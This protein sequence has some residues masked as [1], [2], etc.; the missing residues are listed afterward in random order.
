MKYR[1]LSNLLQ[2]FTGLMIVV[3]GIYLISDPRLLDLEWLR[4]RIGAWPEAYIWS[5][6]TLLVAAGFGVLQNVVSIKPAR[7]VKLTQFLPVA[8]TLVLI[9]GFFIAWSLQVQREERFQQDLV[10]A[11]AERVELE[12]SE[13]IHQTTAALVRYANRVEYLGTKDKSFLDLD[14]RAYLAQLPILKRMGLIDPQNRVIW[15]YPHDIETQVQG[16]NQG[17]EPARLEALT[18]AKESRQPTLSRITNLRSGGAGFIL[19][20][21]LFPKG[22]FNGFIYATVEAD[23]LFHSFV[24]ADN[25]QVVIEEGDRTIFA[26]GP[27]VNLAQVFVHAK[28]LSIGRLP[29]LI[30]ITPTNA[31]VDKTRSLSPHFILFAGVII[32]VLMGAYLHGVSR[33]RRSAMQ[34]TAKVKGLNSQLEGAL[35][36]Q[37][38]ILN[39]SDRAIIS[40]DAEGII[41]TFNPAATFMLGYKP[42]ELIGKATPKIFHVKEETIARAEVLTRELGR[43]VEPGFDAYTIKARTLR[44]ADENEWT[45]VRR[46]G[47][48]VP[49]ML[50]VTVLSD[51]TGSVL[52]Y[53]GMAVDLTEKKKTQEQ[54]VNTNERL[55]RIIEATGE[56]IWERDYV[57]G[58]QIRYLSIQAQRIFGFSSDKKPTYAEIISHVHPEDLAI[59]SGAV[60]GHVAKNSAG[61][62]VEF[63]MR[64]DERPKEYSWIHAR[65]KV[66][67]EPNKE[68]QLVS[69]VRDVTEVVRRRTELKGALAAAEQATRA[70]SE[71]LANIS[72]EIRTPLNG[73]IGMNGLLLDTA[74]DPI[75][76]DYTEMVH[77]SAEM[78]LNLINEVLDF[79]KIEA[80]KVDFESIDFSLAELTEKIRRLLSLA[81]EKKGLHLTTSLAPELSR[82]TFKGDPS[83][84]AQILVNLVNNAIKFTSKGQVEISVSSTGN[85]VR[86]EVRDSGIGMSTNSLARIFQPFTQADASTNRKFGGTGL[87][88]SICKHLV[89][90]MGGEIGVRSVENLGSTF[91]FTLTLPDGDAK[92]VRHAPAASVL[93]IDPAIEKS[94]ILLAEDNPVNQ[95]IATKM[96]EKLGFTVQVAANGNEAL[97]AL[98]QASFDLVLMDCQMPELDGYEATRQIRAAANIA[99]RRVPIVAMTA[100]AMAGDRQRC[101]DAGM[102]D[103]L[104]KPFTAAK[105]I[106][107]I[108]NALRE[109]KAS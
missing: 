35:E 16:Y 107:I 76:R 6:G 95:L 42:E 86:V 69:T 83:R 96:L 57:E 41:R 2:T 22:K 99:I 72:H 80:K 60:S 20:V 15:S 8:T 9:A 56:G 39:S 82:K 43:P 36:W 75:Q 12:I 13:T 94:R 40:T 92:V 3:A 29:W 59:L 108:E 33:S 102:N 10:A 19:P 28:T 34:T 31:Y 50:S 101:L 45:F 93:R 68:P 37:K 61:F 62:D 79:S 18:S 104:V 77:T 32:S 5:F 70:K 103:Y 23:R 52:G 11:E 63:R 26:A 89:E 109:P 85:L 30:R 58:G 53:L 105:L 100:N 21:A 74:L 47:S 14:S 1:A 54:L 24:R 38:A 84:I 71:F 66:V 17:T 27:G 48:L 67:H 87:G 65:G 46:D 25:F 88:L 106:Q 73:V 98:A 49:V 81:A 55:E 90:G 4:L 7:R 51:A 44:V 64:S 91:W 97:K 78:L